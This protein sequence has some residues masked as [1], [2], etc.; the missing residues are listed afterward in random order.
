MD[1]AEV[2]V[3]LRIPSGTSVEEREAA[4]KA[5]RNRLQSPPQ[6]HH[7]TATAGMRMYRHAPCTLSVELKDAPLR[8]VAHVLAVDEMKDDKSPTLDDA[9]KQLRDTFEPT[10]DLVRLVKLWA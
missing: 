6:S 3:A 8:T 4:F 9:I 2:D 7:L 1:G 10:R 5:I